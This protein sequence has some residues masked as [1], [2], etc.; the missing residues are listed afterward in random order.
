M[1]PLPFD[2][3]H[4]YNPPSCRVSG[5]VIVSCP[6]VARCLSWSPRGPHDDPPFTHEGCDRLTTPQLLLP[7]QRIPAKGLDAQVVPSQ[8][9]NRDSHLA[10]GIATILLICLRLR[11]SHFTACLGNEPDTSAID[12]IGWPHHSLPVL[13]RGC[14]HL[15]MVHRGPLHLVT[16]RLPK[17]AI[18]V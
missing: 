9:A 12:H 2:T 13:V 18:P 11:R 4:G 10:R 5:S 3:N 15:T 14:L 16:Q 17:V 1:R 6:F 7:R 8:Q